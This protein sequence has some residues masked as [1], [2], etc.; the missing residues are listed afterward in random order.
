MPKAEGL[1][2]TGNQRRASCKLSSGQDL[3][4]REW[5]SQDPSPVSKPHDGAFS[6]EKKQAREEGWECL[7]EGQ[8]ADTGNEGE[9]DRQRSSR[10]FPSR[11]Q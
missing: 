5:G 10:W 4:G 8:Q 11:A 7:A 9:E 1:L 3:G 2:R 6:V